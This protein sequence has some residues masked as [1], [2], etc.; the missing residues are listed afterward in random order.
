MVLSEIGENLSKA[1]KSSERW[2]CVSTPSIP[3]MKIR[4]RLKNFSPDNHLS[5]P[6][7]Q[8]TRADKSLVHL[9]SKVAQHSVAHEV[10]TH[11]ECGRKNIGATG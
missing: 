5:Q 9:G 7:D 1:C 10:K 6:I 3:A 8:P 11:L 2:K 4:L